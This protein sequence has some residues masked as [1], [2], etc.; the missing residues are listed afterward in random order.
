MHRDPVIF[1]YKKKNYLV[2]VTFIFLTVC[3]AHKNVNSMR[4]VHVHPQSSRNAYGGRCLMQGNFVRNRHIAVVI[5][6]FIATDI[7]LFVAVFKQAYV[8]TCRCIKPMLHV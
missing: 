6:K 2:K 8:C 5:L 1:L 3:Q 7:N 4:S